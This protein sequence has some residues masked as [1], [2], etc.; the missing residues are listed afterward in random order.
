VLKDE[1]DQQL[2]AFERAMAS[3]QSVALMLEQSIANLR[4]EVDREVKLVQED[5]SLLPVV[6]EQCAE[7][8]ENFK[9]IAAE[10]RVSASHRALGCRRAMSLMHCAVPCRRH[11]TCT[12]FLAAAWDRRD[13]SH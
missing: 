13:A 8:A 3:D 10:E 7:V 5:R 6:V 4:S 1:L 12:E 11:F 9:H 2:A